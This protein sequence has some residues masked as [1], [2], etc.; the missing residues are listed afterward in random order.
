M[1]LKTI[2]PPPPLSPKPSLTELVKTLF[3]PR[4]ADSFSQSMSNQ[5]HGPTDQ[6]EN[7]DDNCGRENNIY[8]RDLIRNN[9]ITNAVLDNIY[10]SVT[11]CASNL[12]LLTTRM[13]HFEKFVEKNIK[14]TTA[15]FEKN[16]AEISEISHKAERALSAA[17][18]VD[19]KIQSVTAELL[20][21]LSKMESDVDNKIK[22]K[23]N[24]IKHELNT[25]V[26]KLP[27]LNEVKNMCDSSVAQC[28]NEGKLATRAELTEIN[29]KIGGLKI[30][31][32]PDF[33][34]KIKRLEQ[35]IT[36]LKEKNK[37]LETKMQTNPS[38]GLISNADK[39]VWE[40]FKQKTE[41]ALDDLPALKGDLADSLKTLRSLDVRSRRMNIIIDQL[42]EAEG[43]DTQ[44]SLNNILDHAL[45]PN[46]RQQVEV[47]KAFRLG[48]KTPRGPPRKVFVELSTPKGRD[49]M[50]EN[51]RN[52]SRIGNE[53]K[54]YYLNE[55]LPDDIKRRKNDLHKYVLYLRDRKHQANKIGDD[56]VIDGKRYKFEEL[57]TLPV[58][59][60]FLDSRTIFNGGVVAYQ[61]SVSPLSNLFPCKLKYQG[62]TYTSLEQCYQYHR[63]IHHN[64][65]QLA[66]LIL[67]TN[68]PYKAMYHGKAII[69]EDRDW[70][71]K[72]LPTMEQM[73]R[74]KA[75]Q[76]PIF[77]D[78]LK[79]TG[80][81]RLA[82]N[83]WNYF[84]G[85]GCAFLSDQV[86]I[87]NFRGGNHHGRLLDRVRSSI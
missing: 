39:V 28:I 56:V 34:N 36:G 81:H 11:D 67:S 72:K 71:T 25:K 40:T 41:S 27:T 57:N 30:G 8:L 31:I 52:I 4:T 16:E 44:A 58:G 46:D 23:A 70:E 66:T 82:E 20:A 17:L 65:S 43:E 78:L 24:Q 87:G 26:S 80:S 85:T 45:S 50:L 79:F 15:R 60:R 54:L 2:P 14:K 62:R 1:S 84:W 5:L 74:H 21:M 19:N 53:G 29:N 77:R 64:R 9:R 51:A 6:L 83:S 35:E 12:S 33:D 75:D 73:I 76:V 3:S 18:S 49:V 86:W 38:T 55:D 37:L 13:V 10:T 42:N 63:A 22:F 7:T 47:L 68:D 61:S 59:M 48:T 69:W 32:S